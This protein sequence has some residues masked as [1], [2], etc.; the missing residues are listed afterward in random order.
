LAN[1]ALLLRLSIG[2]MIIHHS[3]EKRA[4]PQRFSCTDVASLQGL[5]PQVIADAAG[6]LKLFGS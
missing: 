1:I 5:F 2:V 3:Q 6:F 4:D